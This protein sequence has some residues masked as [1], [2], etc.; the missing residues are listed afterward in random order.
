MIKIDRKNWNNAS[1]EEKISYCDKLLEESNS[2]HQKR[3]FEWY[4]N[5]M[6]LDGH[7]YASF[8]TVS[9][10]LETPPR[11]SGEV[12]ITINKINSNIRAIKSYATRTEPKWDIVPGDTDENTVKNARRS[13]KFMD[14]LYRTL[15]LE[16]LVEATTE[17]GL[18]TSVAWVEVGWDDK[19]AGGLGQVKAKVHDSFEI[20][21]EPWANLY[22]GKY[23]GR[24]LFK[25]VRKSLDEVKADERYDKKKR[26]KVVG[27]DKLAESKMQERLIRKRSGPLEA[28]KVKRVTIKEVMLWDDESNEKDGNIKLFTYGGG[29]ALRDE[30]LKNK[31]FPIYCMQIPMD[32]RRIYARSWTADAIP[33]NKALDRAVSQKIMYVNQALVYR[34]I[35][36]KGH[37]VNEITN[38][39]G[40]IYEVN[41]NKKFEQMPM[42]VLP[43]TL[44][45]LSGELNT[46][47]EDLLGAHEAALGRIPAGARSGKT[48]EAL[49]A[50]DSNNLAPISKALTSFLSV[51]GSAILDVVAEK[52][53]AS[54]I[55]K[56]TEPEEGGEDLLPVIGAEAPAEAKDEKSTIINKDNE[57]IV[58]IGSWLGHTL[59]AK[60]ETLM[61]MGELGIIPAEEILRQF[62]FPNITE[63]SEKAR[64]QRLEQHQL[65]AEIAGRAGGQ[66][67][68]AVEDMIKLADE[69]N[70]AMMNG[71]VLEPTEGA[72]PEHTTAHGDFINTR[73]F[74]SAPSEVQEVIMAH[75]N[76]ELQNQGVV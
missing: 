49:Q 73:T 63:L 6:F 22:G 72:T 39:Q 3:H 61:R 28:E 57:I 59:E 64:E 4:M 1:D 9:N 68:A 16:S 55:A 27:D 20:W 40:S 56:I 70:T 67:G 33:V 35:A 15:H 65:D 48:L 38:E 7:H 53:V 30:D 76:G 50:A 34:I 19:A 13:G 52:Y 47:I 45:S 12:R 46:Y 54:R 21:P 10:A 32:P 11:K 44:D 18:N 58:K 2:A 23:N 42:Q 36:E 74:Q 62:E 66:G 31:E 60:R 51:L 29:Q 14:Y 37:G 5:Y 69:E 75:Y 17:S 41:S 8:N 24:Y 43:T 25:T 26:K 71:E